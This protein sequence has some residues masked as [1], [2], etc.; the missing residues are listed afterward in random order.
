MKK[1]FMALL[2][3]VLVS[4]L[5]V[6]ASAADFS[7]EEAARAREEYYDAI[8]SVPFETMHGQAL[9]DAYAEALQEAGWAVVDPAAV[10]SPQALDIDPEIL[11]L[12]YSDLDSAVPEMKEKIR[13]ARNEIIFHPSMGWSAA[14]AIFSASVDYEAKVVTLQPRFEDLFPGWE[15]P[16]DPAA[17]E[18]AQGD[19][20]LEVAELA[21]LAPEG[22]GAA[23]ALGSGLLTAYDFAKDVIISFNGSVALYHPTSVQSTPFCQAPTM[24]YARVFFDTWANQFAQATSANY[25]YSNPH[26]TNLGYKG[27][28]KLNE[29]CQ[30]FVGPIGYVNVRASTN[31]PEGYAW[32]IVQRTYRSEGGM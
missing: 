8:A 26:G 3:L 25:G 1:C 28:L 11:E 13:A 21:A 27:G 29:S 32:T 10:P 9:Q 2:V 5:A 20:T 17:G 31:G 6:T 16:M 30:I 24:E 22:D 18:A 19:K 4:L 7:A 14:E 23:L 12:A 15:V